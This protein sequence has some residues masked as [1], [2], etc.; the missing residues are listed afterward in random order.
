MKMTSTHMTAQL[1]VAASILTL[2]MQLR[3][4]VF[5][6]V[7][8]CEIAYKQ[9]HDR[10]K[11]VSDRT[12]KCQREIDPLNSACLTLSKESDWNLKRANEIWQQCY[13]LRDALRKANSP[14]SNSAASARPRNTNPSTGNNSSAGQSTAEAERLRVARYWEQ[15][16]AEEREQRMHAAHSIQEQA[17]SLNERLARDQEEQ[18]AYRRERQAENEE[19]TRQQERQKQIEAEQF[20]MAMHRVAQTSPEELDLFNACGTEMEYANIADMRHGSS[21]DEAV[22]RQAQIAKGIVKDTKENLESIDPAYLLGKGFRNETVDVL[23]CMA[24]RRLSQL[25]G[26]VKVTR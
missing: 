21:R 24:K 26:K 20:A 14:S 8:Q 22:A 16:T 19:M 18:D 1:F 5:N 17:R 15:K 2:P 3:A 11:E 6:T 12:L 23:L 10:Y 4:Q 25:K 7:E 9:Q 13:A